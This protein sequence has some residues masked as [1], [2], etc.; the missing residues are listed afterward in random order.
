MKKIIKLTEQ[1]LTR[2][3]RRIIKEEEDEDFGLP[4]PN[5]TV[6]KER[7]ERKLSEAINEVGRDSEAIYDFL[8][9]RL[10]EI[11]DNYRMEKDEGGQHTWD[12]DER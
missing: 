7:F 1:D 5:K 2:L 9:S 8:I 6:Y 10:D 4:H 12:D 11:M 3:V